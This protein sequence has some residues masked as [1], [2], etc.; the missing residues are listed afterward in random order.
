MNPT[1]RAAQDLGAQLQAAAANHPPPP[2]YISAPGLRAHA[3]SLRPLM[4]LARTA[5]RVARAYPNFKPNES[6]SK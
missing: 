1:A 2:P 3:E 4:P 6:K 5:I